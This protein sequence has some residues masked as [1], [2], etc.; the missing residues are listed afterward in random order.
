MPAY[1]HHE[2]DHLRNRAAMLRRLASQIDNSPALDL[3]RRAG[4]TVWVGPTAQ[5][6]LDELMT[7][8][9]NLDHNADVLRQRARQ[10]EVRAEELDL[11]AFN[12][13]LLVR[14]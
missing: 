2:G 11:A 1:S 8:R 5:R 10:L 7:I 9:R 14:S 3:S 6:C 13:D 12:T 4:M